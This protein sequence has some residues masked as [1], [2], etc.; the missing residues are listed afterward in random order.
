MSMS[1]A[2]SS[3]SITTSIVS[4]VSISISLSFSGPLGNNMSGSNWGGMVGGIW[5][6][7]TISIWV[8]SMGICVEASMSIGVEAIGGIWVGSNSLHLSNS[9]LSSNGG[10]SSNRVDKAM[11]KTVCSISSSCIWKIAIISIKKSCVSLSLRGSINSGKQ[12]NNEELH[13]ELN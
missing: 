10:N 8:S 5:S 4:V 9:R 6:I 11:A 7:G 12:T 3:L 13:L 1:I 2:I